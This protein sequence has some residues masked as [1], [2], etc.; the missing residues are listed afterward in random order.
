MGSAHPKGG[1][2]PVRYSRYARRARRFLR[3]RK[4]DRSFRD[5]RDA[6][7]KAGQ[8]AGH[9]ARLARA[10]FGEPTTIP[11]TTSISVTVCGP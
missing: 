8:R 4:T 6:E 1:G 2:G 9:R 7:T 3:R 5:S 11:F 10:I